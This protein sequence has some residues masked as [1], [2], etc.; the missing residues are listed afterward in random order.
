MMH[1]LNLNVLLFQQYIM[2]QLTP[3]EDSCRKDSPCKP[4][5][6]YRCEEPRHFSCALQYIRTSKGYVSVLILE[7]LYFCS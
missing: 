7:P 5:A 3:G 6:N 1:L 4:S 2:F